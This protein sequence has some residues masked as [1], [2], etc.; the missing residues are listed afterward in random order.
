MKCCL[1]DQ[2][3]GYFSRVIS[4]QDLELGPLCLIFREVKKLFESSKYVNM[5]CILCWS[6]W[7]QIHWGVGGF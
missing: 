3:Q 5:D 4:L 1:A 7:N 6:L 2:L